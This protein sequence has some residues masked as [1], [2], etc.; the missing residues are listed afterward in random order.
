MR[1]LA[2]EGNGVAFNALGAEYNAQGQAQIFQ[3]WTLLNVQFNVGCGVFLSF[4]RF[5]EAVD[6]NP[7]STK[8]IFEANAVLV[9]STAI[10]IDGMFAGKGCRTKKAAAKA[11]TFLVCPI[12]HADG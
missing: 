5:G 9:G 7:T 8:C 12:D 6:L 11:G 1:L 2:M 10:S 4:L 3:Y